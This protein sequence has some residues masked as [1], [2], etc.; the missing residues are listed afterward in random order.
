M[1]IQNKAPA[2]P[3]EPGAERIVDVRSYW[4]RMN[5]DTR[6]IRKTQKKKRNRTVPEIVL[7][8]CHPLHVNQDRELKTSRETGFMKQLI[9]I[10]SIYFNEHRPT[11]AA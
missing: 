7:M 5:R 2:S 9:C 10:N 3:S 8:R 1:S 11:F 4:A 6:Y